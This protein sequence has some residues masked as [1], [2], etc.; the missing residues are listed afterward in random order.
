MG[1]WLEVEGW[2]SPDR[3]RAAVPVLVAVEH[4]VLGRYSSEGETQLTLSTGIE[5]WIALPYAEVAARMVRSTMN[6]EELV[7]YAERENY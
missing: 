7:T 3:G 4:I 2:F 1:D 6:A 5:I